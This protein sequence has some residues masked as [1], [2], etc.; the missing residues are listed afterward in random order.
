MLTDRRKEADSDYWLHWGSERCAAFQ[1]GVSSRLRAEA[2]NG[3]SRRQRKT[4][5]GEGSPKDNAAR[6]D[7]AVSAENAGLR[8][9]RFA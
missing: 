3:P 9:A 2:E 6:L 1:I 4:D 5:L 7:F 8:T